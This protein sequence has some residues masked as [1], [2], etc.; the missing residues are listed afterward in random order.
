MWATACRSCRFFPQSKRRLQTRMPQPKT[1]ADITGAAQLVACDPTA[2][3]GLGVIA[4]GA[5]AVRDGKILALGDNTAIAAMTGPATE[6]IDAAAGIVIAIFD[7]P[8]YR[9]LAFR[10]GASRHAASS[11]TVRF[12]SS[13]RVNGR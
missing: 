13:D 12:L 8:D 2:S 10:F 9:Q 6:V 7:V 11:R 1:Y 4:G 5:V 3:N